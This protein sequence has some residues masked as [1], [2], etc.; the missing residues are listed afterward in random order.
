MEKIID[1][2]IDKIANPIGIKAPHL[3]FLKKFSLGKTDFVF[4]ELFFATESKPLSSE[5][6]FRE[7]SKFSFSDTFFIKKVELLRSNLFL[8]KE[9]SFKNNP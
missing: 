6:F 9:L 1:T 5:R 2:R 3:T 7:E 8:R 4:P